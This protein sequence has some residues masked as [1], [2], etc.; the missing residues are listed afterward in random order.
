MSNVDDVVIGPLPEEVASLAFLL[1][2]WSGSGRGGY[3]TMDPFDYG[4]RMTFDH[5]GDS[6]LLYVQRSWLLSDGSPLH[7]ERGFLRPGDGPGQVELTLA[8]PL[9]LT[10][11]SEGTVTG[12][13]IDLV[14]REIGRTATGSAVTGLERRYRIAGDFFRYELDMATETT[15]MT[16][17]LAAELRRVAT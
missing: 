9:G 1:G 2:S 16:R 4:E 11:V 6:F 14:S 3:P 10:E 13:D 5:V 7:F 12:G 15:P 8:H 17:H